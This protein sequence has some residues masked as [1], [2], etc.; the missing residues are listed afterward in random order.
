M[1]CNPTTPSVFILFYVKL[2]ISSFLRN[3]APPF[4]NLD[5]IHHLCIHVQLIEPLWQ[6]FSFK[7]SFYLSLSLSFFA[8]LCAD[9]VIT[10]IK[11]LPQVVLPVQFSKYK[12]TTLHLQITLQTESS[13]DLNGSLV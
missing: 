8:L 13:C 4:F 3:S 6:P 9:C 5:Y 2:I 10:I 12:L 11:T 1:Q 7:C